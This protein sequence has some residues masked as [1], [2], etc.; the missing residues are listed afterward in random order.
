MSW[1]L[2]T[3]LPRNTISYFLVSFGTLARVP[4][5]S[6]RVCDTLSLSQQPYPTLAFRFSESRQVTSASPVG[7]SCP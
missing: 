6:Y 1:V 2:T 5:E 4:S 7:E 3:L